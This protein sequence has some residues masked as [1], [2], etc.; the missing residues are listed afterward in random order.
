MNLLRIGVLLLCVVP[1]LAAVAS[2]QSSR[3]KVEET[4][5]IPGRVIVDPRHASRIA[6]DQAGFLEAPPEGFP[7]AGSRVRAGQVLAYLR[8]SIPQLERRDLDADLA[9]AQRDV[10]LGALQVQRFNANEVDEFDGQVPLPSIQILGDYR[11]AQVRETALRSALG[12]R[13]ALLAPVDAVILNSD[14]Y[15]G[16]AVGAGETLFGMAGPQ[17]LVIEVLSAREVSEPAAI[18]RLESGSGVSFETRL[19]AQRFD[20][21]LRAH[22]LLYAI[23]PAA[24]LGIGQ[25]VSLSAVKPP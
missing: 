25:P 17:G 20:P 7:A 10:T 11:S 13:I 1:G 2:P 19:L 12:G 14:V 9:V 15:A 24:N 4:F 16:R 18:N 23:D 5:T 21:A 8:P 3:Q 6:A 22:R